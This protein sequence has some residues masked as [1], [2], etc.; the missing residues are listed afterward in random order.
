MAT[1]DNTRIDVCNTC[2]R[3]AFEYISEDVVRC[4][5]CT[6]LWVRPPDDPAGGEAA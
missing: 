2:G 5:H 3:S 1:D 4:T 6:Y